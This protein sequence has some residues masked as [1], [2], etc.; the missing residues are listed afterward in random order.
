MKKDFTENECM[1][2]IDAAINELVY[3]KWE[4][5][6]NYNYYN[7]K[8]DP[9]QFEYLEQNFGIGNPTE[10]NFTPLVKKHIDA[11]VGDYLG[12][13]TMPRVTCKDSQTLSI[14][15]REKQL[16]SSNR[17]FE[18]V[19]TKIKD[20]VYA[21][22]S[23]KKVEDPIYSE[24][25]KKIV[26]DL[27][28]NYISNFEIAA[29]NVL[30]YVMQSRSIDFKNK[31]RQ[32]MLD[33]LISGYTFYQ[34]HKSSKGNNI[35]VEIL[36]PL[37]TYIDMNP[38]SQYIKDSY[39][40]VIVK[41][42]NRSQ[43][44]NKFGSKLSKE[45]LDKIDEL[46]SSSL[47]NYNQIFIRSMA[48][49]PS[50]APSGGENDLD[51]INVFPG[52]PT[53]MPYSQI[54]KLVPVYEVEWLHTGDDFVTNRYRGYRIGEEI[55]IIEGK[56]EEAIRSISNPNDCGLSVNGIMMTNRSGK[57]YS[58]M[59]A[60][61]HLQDK[62][63]ILMFFRDT[64]IAN[65][66]VAGDWVDMSNLPAELGDNMIDRLKMFQAYKKT[67]VALIN[68]A[69]EGRDGNNLNTI[70]GGYDDSLKLQPIQAIEVSL[71]R[72]EDTCSSITGVFKERLNGIQSYDAVSNVRVGQNNS[73]IVTSHIMNQMDLVI[74]EMLSDCLNIA[75]IVYSTGL[76]GALVIGE[77]YQKTFDILPKYYTHT[78]FDIHIMSGSE[79]MKDLE[80]I[81]ATTAGFIQAGN[82]DADII[83]DAMTA[84][85][86][87]E[88]K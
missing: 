42:M 55:Y 28:M 1:E 33:L 37:N 29:Q 87:T 9:K 23:G 38:E 45:D 40:V 24:E 20:M 39:R 56:D 88:L 78:D 81:K 54:N 75:K 2:K 31:K 41:W 85:S 43:V 47:S 22:I 53:D 83:V 50:V 30:E 82:L 58:L 26:G 57:P 11:L 79:I 73:L 49:S 86:I 71:Q 8:R 46:Y 4:M 64:M 13:M 68:T 62:Y 63:D 12:V 34:A 25:I 14:I 84:K 61:A 32:L 16:E 66:G 69:Q 65:A 48:N 72:I 76:Q 67:G 77:R 19:K 80:A 60:C 21:N 51:N 6:R 18:Y 35:E 7:C 3:P 36:N 52:F 74:E 15:N 44:R 5:Q 27:D 17:L 10:I 59:G 70:Y